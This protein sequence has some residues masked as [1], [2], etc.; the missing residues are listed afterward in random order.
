MI[1]AIAVS[2]QPWCSSHNQWF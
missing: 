2:N 1:F